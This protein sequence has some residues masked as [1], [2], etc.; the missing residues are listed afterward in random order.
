MKKTCCITGTGGYLGGCLVRYFSSH[1]WK[2]IELNR[3]GR[4]SAGGAEAR[5]YELGDAFPADLVDVGALVHAAY[6]FKATTWK[7]ILSKNV[8]GT[9][10]L[11]DSARRAGVARLLF[12]SSMSAFTGC[13]SL[14]G[15]AKL[16]SEAHLESLGGLSLRPG[17][18][19]DAS[20]PGGMVGKLQRLASL[21]PILPIPGS[22]R[23][24]LYFTHQEDLCRIAERYCSGIELG[25]DNVLIAANSTPWMFKH[26]LREIAHRQN[27]TLICVPTPWQIPWL[28]LRSLELL[29]INLPLKSDS[30][31]SLLNQNR[32]PS[33]KENFLSEFKKY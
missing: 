19:H 2:V 32:N 8:E 13:R 24:I 31:L 17:L 16:L 9:D 33:F 6:D 3:N 27:R 28:A 12:I 18:I 7:E 4:I 5:R 1:G 22:G 25:P 14:Y 15:R 10:R 11:F 29:G 23:D 30:L 20:Q 21:S 26:I